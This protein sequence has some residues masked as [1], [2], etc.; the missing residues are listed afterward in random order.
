MA[1][2]LAHNAAVTK[3]VVLD[4]IMG[5]A[6]RVRETGERTIAVKNSLSQM[7][8]RIEGEIKE[9]T[10]ESCQMPAQRLFIS[11]TQIGEQI[12]EFQRTSAHAESHI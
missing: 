7:S 2:A 5:M 3:V 1:S 9:T 11:Y 10:Q 8:V 4:A 6:Q 12:A